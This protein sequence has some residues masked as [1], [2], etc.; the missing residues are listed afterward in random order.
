M[1]VPRFQLRA[2]PSLWDKGG[3]LAKV[4]RCLLVLNL[5]DTSPEGRTNHRTA[6]RVPL[7]KAHQSRHLRMHLTPTQLTAPPALLVVVCSFV[8]YM[9]PWPPPS[10][11]YQTHLVFECSDI[12]QDEL[13]PSK[14]INPVPKS[15]LKKY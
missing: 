15:D 7:L 12:G 4:A 13:Y 14:V 11:S 1:P 3:G 8:S 5:S 10:S 9:L 2:R 6:Q